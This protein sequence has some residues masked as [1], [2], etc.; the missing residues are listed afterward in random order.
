[1]FGKYLR[2]S[3]LVGVS[4]L[5]LAACSPQAVEAPPPATVAS[6]AP[7]ATLPASAPAGGLTVVNLPSAISPDAKLDPAI[8]SGAPEDDGVLEVSRYVY[9]TLVRVENGQVVPGLA[10]DWQV[11]D[12]GLTYQFSLR[13]NS[14]F[15]DGT[16]VSTGV[17]MDNVNR[18]FDP[19]HP[20]HGSDSSVYQTWLFYFEGFRD[21]FDE[22]GAPISTFDGIE[23][24]DDLRFLL[25]IF[26]P[27]EDFL[28]ILADPQF[29]IL[30]P[31]VLAAEGA[32]YGTR[33]GSV[34]G[35]GPYMIES[36]NESGMVLVPNPLY[37]GDPAQDQLVFP[38]P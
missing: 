37:W 25:H 27:R 6:G 18:W 22:N 11:S 15:S 4:V 10:T 36:W 26:S 7:A 3:L 17:V 9:D 23:K 33:S 30:N 8:V 13:A 32:R 28:K 16:P 24:V 20:L 29:S 5:V 21:Q 1:M 31:T 38:A 2:I 19:A 35:T 14:S 34:D 12:D